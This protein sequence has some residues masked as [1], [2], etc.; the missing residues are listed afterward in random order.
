MHRRHFVQLAAGAL[1]AAA[2]GPAL[3]QADSA[4]PP[5]LRGRRTPQ[6]LPSAGRIATRGD[7]ALGL[8]LAPPYVRQGSGPVVT[9]AGYAGCP[10]MAAFHRDFGTRGDGVE[11]HFFPQPLGGD[12]SAESQARVTTNMVSLLLHPTPQNLSL[13]LDGRLP[14]YVPRLREGHEYTSSIMRALSGAGRK[15]ATKPTPDEPMTREQFLTMW[16]EL[17]RKQLGSFLLL[18]EIL[19]QNGLSP[20]ST[21][22]ASPSF[23]W[24]RDGALLYANGY[25][26]SP[27]QRARIAAIFASARGEA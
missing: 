15:P 17:H 3:A 16:D 27:E 6:G 7:E 2:I 11:T 1:A 18:A 4:L 21:Q 10:Y 13:Y 9:I 19:S 26:S 23:F 5:A 14:P 24:V 25:T 20:S 8:L 22:M 12:D